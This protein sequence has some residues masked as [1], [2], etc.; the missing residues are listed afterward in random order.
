MYPLMKQTS[1]RSRNTW[2]AARYVSS[3]WYQCKLLIIQTADV[4]EAYLNSRLPPSRRLEQYRPV[5]NQVDGQHSSHDLQAP[6][7]QGSRGRVEYEER[8]FDVD[9]AEMADLRAS[10]LAEDLTLNPMNSRSD[11]RGSE[12]TVVSRVDKAAK[13]KSDASL[14][15]KLTEDDEQV[16]KSFGKRK[17]KKIIMG[18]CAVEDGAFYDMSFT[19]V[20]IST[21]KKQWFFCLFLNSMAC[22]FHRAHWQREAKGNQL[23]WNWLRL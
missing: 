6:K 13:P 17:A 11:R 19:R 14:P 15:D 10:E 20:L 22:K 18:Q 23:V 2:N 9:G 3:V 5:S 16:I 1:G 21:I 12:V 7:L 4:M 8:L